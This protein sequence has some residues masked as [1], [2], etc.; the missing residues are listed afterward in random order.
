MNLLLDVRLM[1]CK[2]CFCRWQTRK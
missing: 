2:D 1:E